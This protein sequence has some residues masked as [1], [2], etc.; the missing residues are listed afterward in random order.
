MT[1][2]DSA[3]SALADL[4][5]HPLRTGLTMLGM[6]FGVGAVVAMLSIGEG[7][8]R[9]ALEMI[10]RLGVRN[11][12]LRDLE[13]RDSEL[14]EARAISPGLS[15]RDAEAILDAVP[16]VEEAC[17]KVSFDPYSVLSGGR[18]TE[19]SALGVS[20]SYA[21]L[22]SLDVV[23]G[24]FLDAKDERD[25]AQVA[26][27][28][29]AVRRELFGSDAALG[30][31]LKVDD[32]WLEVVGVLRGTGGATTVQGV[33]VGS[34]EREIY[35]PVT[36]AM[37]KL[38]RPWME[39][40]L[41]EIVL[42]LAESAEPRTVADLVGSLVDRLHGGARDFSLVVPD[43]LLEQSRRT[44]RLFSLVMGA[45]A[46]ISLLVGGIGIA[47]I[48]LATVFERT[49]EIGIRRAVGA[50]RRDIRTLFLMESFAISGL[51]GLAGVV[52]GVALAK[53]VA[54]SAGWPT[55]VTLWS[56]LLSSGV[57]IAVGLVSGLYPA[58]RA[59]ELNP[60]EALRW[61]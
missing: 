58:V 60:I 57:A 36:T 31:V 34:T 30:A 44:Q 14:E 23:E 19:A 43:A 61:E 21:R 52:V 55:V 18:T 24:R 37:R 20:A 50:T 27:I 59:A 33:A 10:E 26:V 2:A 15:P 45:I 53:I 48:M 49:R 17:L 47:N 46:G 16:G 3:R 56:V 11:L 13:M 9:Q 25:H 7:A 41:D 54:V 1:L 39:A 5:G 12:I 28:G 8:E 35:L 51:G 22:T 4:S 29:E 38:D 42:R 40:P 32:L 6:V